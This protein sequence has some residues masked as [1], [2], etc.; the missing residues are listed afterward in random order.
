[1]AGLPWA[2]LGWL[3]VLLMLSGAAF[4]L[5]TS[6]R[7]TDTVLFLA[8]T[9]FTLLALFMTNPLPWQ[10]YYLPLTVPLAVL[11]GLGFAAWGRIIRHS[12]GSILRS[13][14]A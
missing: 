8:I 2:N 9:G 5:K 4:M 3:A 1:V 14:Y 10:R 6:G 13:R 7:R 11:M 12:A